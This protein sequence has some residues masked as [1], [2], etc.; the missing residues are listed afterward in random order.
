M[1]ARSWVGLRRD[2]GAGDAGV[3]H[4]NLTGWAHHDAQTACCAT[5]CAQTRC[6]RTSHIDCQGAHGGRGV[7]RGDLSTEAIE[8]HHVLG[9]TDVQ[10]ISP[11]TRWATLK[12][13]GRRGVA[14]CAAALI[15]WCCIA[16][17]VDK[18]KGA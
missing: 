10:I 6:R 12:Y 14:R 18:P 17:Q 16:G 3:A 5:T 7:R 8:A 13:E 4:A 9:G 1:S 11:S 2:A 15:L